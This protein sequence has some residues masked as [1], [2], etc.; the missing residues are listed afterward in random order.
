MKIIW[1]RAPITYDEIIR[2]V[3]VK[4]HLDEKKIYNTIIYLEKKQLIIFEKSKL[5]YVCYP[6]MSENDCRKKLK[7]SF[8]DKLRTQ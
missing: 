1:D 4:Y 2:E 8:L 3:Q 6:L 7:K 5:P